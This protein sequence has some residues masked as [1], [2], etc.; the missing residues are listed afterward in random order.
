MTLAQRRLDGGAGAAAVE[1]TRIAEVAAAEA[2][3][4]L[5]LWPMAAAQ[6]VD[7]YAHLDHVPHLHGGDTVCYLP[8]EAGAVVVGRLRR[9]AESPAA[10]LTEEEGHLEIGARQSITLRTGSSRIELTSDG[11]LR[12]DGRD[13]EHVA[14]RRYS[15]MGAVIELN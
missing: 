7:V 9:S 12:I 14:E 11:H 6:P 3:E 2:G 10:R 5:T 4:A 1:T 15:V 13:I 8:S